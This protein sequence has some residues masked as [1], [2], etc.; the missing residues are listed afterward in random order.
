M[1]DFLN[2]NS[3]RISLSVLTFCILAGA[4]MRNIKGKRK[5]E[6]KTR[7]KKTPERHGKGK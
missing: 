7:M 1:S 4:K 5:T 6:K 2:R 3:I